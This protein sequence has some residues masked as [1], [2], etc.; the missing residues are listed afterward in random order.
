MNMPRRSFTRSKTAV[1]I[2][3]AE[4]GPIPHR[5]TMSSVAQVEVTQQS[6]E[7]RQIVAKLRNNDVLQNF[8][9]NAKMKESYITFSPDAELLDLVKKTLKV[10]TSNADSACHNA[11]Q[12]LR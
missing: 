7:L 3:N 8:S 2:F 10:C 9:R 6:E 12:R 1:T 11:A 4:I 5:S